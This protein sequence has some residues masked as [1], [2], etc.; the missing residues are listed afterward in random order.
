L[1]VFTVIN[2]KNLHI[3]LKFCNG[4]PL[5]LH[6]YANS[7]KSARIMSI[8]NKQDDLLYWIA[9]KQVEGVGNV[10]YKRLIS[11][12]NTARNVFSASY[13]ELMQVEGL[14]QTVAN[15]IKQFDNF[16]KAEDELYRLERHSIKIITLSDELYPP[17]LHQIDDPPP[18]LY[19]K[20]KLDITLQSPCIAV[21]GT[22]F[23]SPYG[24]E[25]TEEITLALVKEGL[26]IVSGM[27]KG[28]DSIAHKTAIANAGKTIAVWGNGIN[29]VYPLENK[30]LAQGIEKHGLILTEYPLDTPPLEV[31]FPERNRIISGMSIAVVVTEASLNSGTMI[32]VSHALDQGREVF[33]VPGQ[34]YSMMS[35]GTNRLIKHGCGVVDSVD[36]FITE[37]KALLP[38]RTTKKEIK[39][40]IPEPY[41]KVLSVLSSKPVDLDTIIARLKFDTAKVMSILTEMEL[42]GIVKQLPGKQFIKTE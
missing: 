8:K 16:S 18:F 11:S 12:F 36:S 27:A 31:N 19:A 15:N 3:F 40:D 21:V 7:V 39:L 37:I 28:I 26:T 29:K 41:L 25:V 13:D 34:I 6:F 30:Q 20:G 14:S 4:K 17:L 22:R 38:S 24:K 42:N 5:L 2:H 33:A 35:Q 32:T 10:F 9:L 1:R 23:P